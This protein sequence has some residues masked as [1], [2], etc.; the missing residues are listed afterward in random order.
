MLVV[1]INPDDSLVEFR[2]GR[3]DHLVVF[4]LGIAQSVESLQHKLEQ[5]LEIF[6]GRTG[7][8][9]V[10]VAGRTREGM[11]AMAKERMA[12]YSFKALNPACFETG[13]PA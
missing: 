13:Q 6:R 4:M 5:G 1:D 10:G 11:H 9:D 8:K 12:N 2:I 7:N 3:L